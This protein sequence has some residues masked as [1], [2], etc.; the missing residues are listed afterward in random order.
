MNNTLHH[1]CFRIK[2]SFQYDLFNSIRM[3]KGTPKQTFKFVWPLWIDPSL[4]AL[5]LAFGQRSAAKLYIPQHDDWIQWRF[6]AVL[7]NL[8]CGIAIYCKHKKIASTIFF[9]TNSSSEL[10][11]K[12]RSRKTLWPFPSVDM[13]RHVK[14]M[15]ELSLS[16]SHFHHFQKGTEHREHLCRVQ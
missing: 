4:I 16:Q 14:L 10:F 5:S 1:K 2:W 6:K 9:H 13:E 15:K 7:K 3:E 11:C 12:E 8:N